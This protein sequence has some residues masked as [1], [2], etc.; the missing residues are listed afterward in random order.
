MSSPASQSVSQ[1]HH[2][3]RWWSGGDAAIAT[4]FWHFGIPA[5]FLKLRGNRPTTGQKIEY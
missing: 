4:H 2:R 5:H 3:W 1:H